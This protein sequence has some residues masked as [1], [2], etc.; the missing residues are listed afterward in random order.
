MTT[1][2]LIRHGQTDAIGHHLAAPPV[3]LN[4]AGR[5]EAR[6]LAQRLRS[7]RFD[8]VAAS[9]MPRTC[10]TAEPIAREQHIEVTFVPELTEFEFGTWSGQTFDVLDADDR[11][12]NFN[13]ARS[14][15]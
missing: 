6:Q 2:Y 10:Q 4:D 8:A 1:L 7:V 9:P 3:D 11:W 14:L 5:T 13:V 12:R 15:T